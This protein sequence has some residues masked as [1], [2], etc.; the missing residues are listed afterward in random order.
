MKSLL[1]SSLVVEK[2]RACRIIRRRLPRLR[3]NQVVVRVAYAAICATDVRIFQG[4]TDVR[5]PQVIGHDFCGVVEESR[6]EL[7]RWRP[8]SVVAVDPAY[9][10]CRCRHCISG[11]YNLCEVGTWLGFELPGGLAERVIVPDVCLVPLPRGFDLKLGALLEPVVVALH[12]IEFM[13]EAA[14]TSVALLG[15]GAIGLTLLQLLQLHGV[16]VMGLDPDRRALADARALGAR[17][18]RV[19]PR[20][21]HLLT[22][23]LPRSLRQAFD[24]VVECSGV[25]SAVDLS[26]TLARPGGTILQVGSGRGLHGPTIELEKE[27]TIQYVELGPRLYPQ[28]IHLAHTRRIDLLPLIGGI[29]GLGDAPRVLQALSSN[30]PPRG[31][32]I[33]RVH[34]P[35]S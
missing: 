14:S 22:A 9:H 21:G 30:H 7:P 6:S 25:Q 26:T 8:G 34:P 3:K 18:L 20:P 13:A 2:P 1:S 32:F 27:L 12:T 35:E 4:R 10:C 5:L 19:L 29:S 31:R 24:Y 23:V 17:N 16:Q 11:R 33:V 28:A 15:L